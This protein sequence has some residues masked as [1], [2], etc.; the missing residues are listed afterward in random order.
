[1]SIRVLV[2]NDPPVGFDILVSDVDTVWMQNPMPYMAKF[3][4]ADILTSSDHL[5]NTAGSKGGLEDPNVAHSPA[6][7]G[8]MLLRHTAKELAQ[9]GLCQLK[10]FD[11][12]VKVPGSSSSN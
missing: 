12:R 8:I 11:N 6:N 1:M 3:P 7:I 4:M 10:L 9:V 5:A 2:L